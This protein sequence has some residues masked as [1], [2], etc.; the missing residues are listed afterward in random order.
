MVNWIVA[1]IPPDILLTAVLA[2]STIVVNKCE[3]KLKSVV[4]VNSGNIRLRSLLVTP[5][6]DNI[7]VYTDGHYDMSDITVL[8]RRPL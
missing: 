5:V 4:G 8:H 2:L 7:T 6:T 3:Y 1:V